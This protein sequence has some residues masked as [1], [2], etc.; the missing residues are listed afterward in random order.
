MDIFSST[1]KFIYRLHFNEEKLDLI[2]LRDSTSYEFAGKK[3]KI[4][5]WPATQFLQDV[6]DLEQILDKM[7]TEKQLRVKEFEKL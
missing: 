5:I 1:E 3:D 7:N 6:S 4:T 2:E